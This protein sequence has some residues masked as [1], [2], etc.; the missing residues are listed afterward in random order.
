MYKIQFL[1]EIYNFYIFIYFFFSVKK[2][3]FSIKT[4][5]Y[6]TY[7]H[8]IFFSGNNVYFCQKRKYFF[9]KK[10]IFQFSF[11]TNEQPQPGLFVKSYCLFEPQLS[12]LKSKNCCVTVSLSSRRHS[13]PIFA[14]C[15]C[16]GKPTKSKH[17]LK[18]NRYFQLLKLVSI[19]WFC[20]NDL[21]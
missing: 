13:D 10:S 12:S 20:K 7:F 3:F 9:K 2:V 18:T 8:I 17:R 16:R 19:N 5:Q 1:N 11:A 6:K 4:F 15:Y 21:F 14:G